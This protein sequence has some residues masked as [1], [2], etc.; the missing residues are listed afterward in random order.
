MAHAVGNPDTR[1][2]PEIM[3]IYRSG[4]TPWTV[5]ID[6]AGRVVYN[7]FHIKE[8]QAVSLIELLTSKR[9]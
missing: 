7:N 6:T 2:I 8:T 5:I 9:K 3:R 4:G 1:G